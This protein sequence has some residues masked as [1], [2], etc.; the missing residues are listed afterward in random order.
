MICY[1]CK[2]NFKMILTCIIL[3]CVW[4]LSQSEAF[5][6]FLPDANQNYVFIIITL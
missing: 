4:G 6:I 1:I 5:C 3:K 2:E